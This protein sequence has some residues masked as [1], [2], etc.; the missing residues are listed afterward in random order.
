MFKSLIDRGNIDHGNLILESDIV[1]SSLGKT[2]VKWH[3]A[4]LEAGANATA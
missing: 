3:L 4:T 2:T 1:E